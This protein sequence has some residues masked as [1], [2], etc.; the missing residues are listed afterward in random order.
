MDVEDLL[1]VSIGSLELGDLPEGQWR[2][3]KKKE[4]EEIKK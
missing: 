3:L 2:P 1:R 4:I